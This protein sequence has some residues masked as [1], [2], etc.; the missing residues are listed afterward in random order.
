MLAP[1]E[2]N[3]WKAFRGVCDG[4]VP[5]ARLKELQKEQSWELHPAQLTRPPW[6]RLGNFPAVSG[7]QEDEEE[8]GG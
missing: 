8:E 1:L 5:S 7:S 2:S 6:E 3:L 4:S